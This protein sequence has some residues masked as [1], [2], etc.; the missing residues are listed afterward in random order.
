MKN[1]KI[2]ANLWDYHHELLHG[3]RDPM[4][5]CL[6]CDFANVSREAISA[7]VKLCE[8]C[9]LKRNKPKKHLVVKPIVSN[10]HNSRGQVAMF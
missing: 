8:E 6:K 1:D 7:F 2:F 5:R 4:E 9:E 3:G 10:K